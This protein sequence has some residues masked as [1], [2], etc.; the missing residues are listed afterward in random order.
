M[1]IL[2]SIFSIGAPSK[3]VD[4]SPVFKLLDDIN[5]R[6]DKERELDQKLR[7]EANEIALKF[8]TDIKGLPNDINKTRILFEDTYNNFKSTYQ[9]FQNAG[10]SADFFGS[11]QYLD[12]VNDLQKINSENYKNITRQEEYK[13][14]QTN[15]NNNNTGQNISYE[16]IF[17]AANNINTLIVPKANYTGQELTNSGLLD[18]Y[19]TNLDYAGKPMNNLIAESNVDPKKAINF[20]YGLLQIVG[21]RTVDNTD[22]VI[23]YL[24][25][26]DVDSE[27]KS[28]IS[29]WITTRTNTNEL[30]L[31]AWQDA[32]N[33]GSLFTQ[34]MARNIKNAMIN[35]MMQDSGGVNYNSS[36]KVYSVDE[37]KS[38]IKKVDN[39]FN[40]NLASIIKNIAE[41]NTNKAEDDQIIGGGRG[42]GSSNKSDKSDNINVFEN[43]MNQSASNIKDHVTI[44]N[45]LNNTSILYDKASFVPVPPA[46]NDEVKGTKISL[47]GSLGVNIPLAREYDDEMAPDQQSK[48]YYNVHAPADYDDLYSYFKA[49]NYKIDDFF[50]EEVVKQLKIYKPN[51]SSGTLIELNPGISFQNT[52][53]EQGEAEHWNNSKIGV[54]DDVLAAMVIGGSYHTEVKDAYIKDGNKATYGYV[55][56]TNAI[57][58]AKTSAPTID[59]SGGYFR[60]VIDNLYLD[61]KITDEKY[62]ELKSNVKEYADFAKIKD[63]STEL[64]KYLDNL[65]NSLMKVMP[66]EHTPM[67]TYYYEKKNE[68]LDMEDLRKM[69][70]AISETDDK[71]NTYNTI[72][73]EIPINN[74]YNSF[75]QSTVPKSTYSK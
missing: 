70:G 38:Y 9:Q 65:S 37:L 19:S 10:R 69:Y 30:N 52:T 56:F 44:V 51:N 59:Y 50:S 21:S 66:K 71:G 2:S 75:Y 22:D 7:S 60:K 26:S 41:I 73:P 49:N 23:A 55:D 68:K 35:Q 17:N 57:S 16:A 46:L 11:F 27:T 39:G 25:K 4:Y 5:L 58:G 13:T 3:G 29:S 48:I 34:D 67:W 61:K 62:K 8:G 72:T 63:N 20:F 43:Y 53:G 18:N 36:T 14:A 74:L 6:R 42:T 33:D 64:N 31:Q 28:K 12:L 15:I 54:S 32:I 1:P 47:I 24:E 45:G 40:S